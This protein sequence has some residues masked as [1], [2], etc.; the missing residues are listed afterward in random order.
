MR[1]F[2]IKSYLKICRHPLWGDYRTLRCST[3]FTIIVYLLLVLLIAIILL[4]TF[5]IEKR[6]MMQ[7]VKRQVWQDASY[8]VRFFDDREKAHLMSIRT[9]LLQ[10]VESVADIDELGGNSIFSSEPLDDVS[11]LKIP[12]HTSSASSFASNGQENFLPLISKEQGRELAQTESFHSIFNVLGNILQDTKKTSPR[13]HRQP[14]VVGN[15]GSVIVDQVDSIVV[16]RDGSIVIERGPSIETDNRAPHRAGHHFGEYQ[17]VAEESDMEMPLVEVVSAYVYSSV[18]GFPINKYIFNLMREDKVSVEGQVRSSRLHRAKTSISKKIA[19]LQPPENRSQIL[20]FSTDSP[21]VDPE[22]RE[23]D[24]GYSYM[25]VYVPIFG[26]DKNSRIAVLGLVYRV[27]GGLLY[28]Q[29]LQNM[30]I[31]FLF[32]VLLLSTIVVP[33]IAQF[34]DRPFRKFE[35]SLKEL[36]DSNFSA[37]VQFPNIGEFKNLSMHMNKIKEQMTVD[38]GASSDIQHSYERFLPKVWLQQLGRA[39]VTELR[40]GD[41]AEK[42]MTVMFVDIRSYYRIAAKMS[43]SENFRFMNTFL[44]KLSPL[45]SQNNGFIDKFIGDAIMAL[46]PEP[47]GRMNVIGCAVEMQKA[48]YEWNREFRDRVE[49]VARMSGTTLSGGNYI[50]V[51]I[52]LHYGKVALGILGAADRLEGTVISSAVNLA[53]RLENLTKYFG[54]NILI[55]EETWNHC[56]HEDPSGKSEYTRY[57]GSVCVKGSETPVRIFEVF[58]GDRLVSRE[59]KLSSKLEFERGV[60]LY[61]KLRFI[62]A[63]EIFSSLE[64]QLCQ[65]EDANPDM[66]LLSNASAYEKQQQGERPTDPIRIYLNQAQVKAMTIGNVESL[67]MKQKRVVHS[68]SISIEQAVRAQSA[69]LGGQ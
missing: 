43:P 2:F 10:K 63:I 3:K 9:A 19:Y 15:D 25:S 46:F 48:T 64:D 42:F 34:L 38:R 53:S 22:M 51:G 69:E 6:E 40:L 41:Y 36:V 65:I 67:Q 50:H 24:L 45:I 44:E 35:K 18:P 27:E 8:M 23:D 21:I 57:L 32:L 4:W 55:S 17:G 13:Y 14:I 5:T 59:F 31:G 12:K 11:R 61:E 52:G 49:T 66:M 33:K 29:R 56:F 20:A 7:L 26:E 28:I 60:L 47:E 58:S 37:T 62:E 1:G 68:S 54:T 16:G 39:N 30:S